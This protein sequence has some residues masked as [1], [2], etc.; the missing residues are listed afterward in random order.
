MIYIAANG[1][2]WDSVAYKT[3]GDEFAFETLIKAN[4]DLCE[5]VQF[6]GGEK[7]TIPDDEVYQYSTNDPNN[8]TKVRV[9]SAPWG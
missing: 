8:T 2:T 3:L 7:V 4:Y 6:L 9:I 1:D 5:I